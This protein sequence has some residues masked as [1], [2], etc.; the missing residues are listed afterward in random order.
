MLTF[1]AVQ[2][3]IVALRRSDPLRYRPFRVP[4]NL[5]VSGRS[6][7][8]PAVAGAAATAALWVATLVL[9][10]RVGLLGTA[11][12]AAGLA[13]YAAYRRRLGI[14]LT[15]TRRRELPDSIGPDI[16]VEFHTTL[17]PINTDQPDIPT[18]VVEVAARMAAER[19][20]SIVLV[21]FT[22]IPLG[23]DLDLEIDGLDETVSRIAARVRS[24]TDRYG[25]RVHLT[26]LRTRDPVESILQEAGPQALRDHP[27]RLPPACIGP[28]TGWR[29]MTPRSAGSRPR[30]ASA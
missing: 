12:M 5:T 28:G 22:E 6:L 27:D 25:I 24:V 20:A 16:E 3:S 26:H 15:E 14:S 18:D 29:S 30:R 4:L 13:G 17:I 9:A 2:V 23:E 21:A 7:P 1:T 19:R 8:L 11:W 10:P